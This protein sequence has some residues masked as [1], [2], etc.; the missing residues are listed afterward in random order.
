MSA[1][2]TGPDLAWQSA[3]NFLR[4]LG[5][6]NQAELTMVLDIAMNPNSVYGKQTRKQP[7]NPHA[8]KLSVEGDLRPVVDFLLGLGLDQDTVAG[9]I[10]RHPAV[11]CYSVEER[12]KPLVEYLVGDMQLPKQQVVAALKERPH[13]LGLQLESMKRMVGYLAAN[14]KG[15]EEIAQ[16]LATTL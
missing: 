11:L 1:K 13:M 6:N 4:G 3:A 5:I 9:I 15:M 7:V 8:R 2:V 12:L 16:L 10:L 14:G